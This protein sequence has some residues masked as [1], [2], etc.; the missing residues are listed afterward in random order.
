MSSR[1]CLDKQRRAWQ[2]ELDECFAKLVIQD[3]PENAMDRGAR[4]GDA[5]SEATQKWF[6][7]Y[8]PLGPVR[9][10]LNKIWLTPGSRFSALISVDNNPLWDNWLA[11]VFPCLG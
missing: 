9:T 6:H 1:P 5:L 11:F 10:L 8:F 4:I 2:M 3:Q 7:E